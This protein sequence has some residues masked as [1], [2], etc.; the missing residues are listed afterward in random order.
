MQGITDDKDDA[1][2]I[3]DKLVKREFIHQGVTHEVYIPDGY[4]LLT[5]AELRTTISGMEEAIAQLKESQRLQRNAVREATEGLAS[6]IVRQEK[7]LQKKSR[8]ILAMRQEMRHLTKAMSYPVKFVWWA[9]RGRSI[10]NEERAYEKETQ[11]ILRTAEE[12]LKGPV[13]SRGN[14]TTPEEMK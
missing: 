9:F 13:D 14:R 4:R 2:T 11:S 10:R 8:E 1:T 3:R 6:T 7:A 5:K 12:L